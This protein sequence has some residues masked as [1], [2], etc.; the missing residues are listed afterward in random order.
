MSINLEINKEN[1]LNYLNESKINETELN[2]ESKLNENT[3]NKDIVYTNFKNEEN[4]DSNLNNNNSINDNTQNIE[5]FKIENMCFYPTKKFPHMKVLNANFNLLKE[6]LLALIEKDK[7]EKNEDKFFQP[8]IEHDLYEES[9][10]NGWDVGP[11]MIGGNYIENNCKKA[12][13][14]YN[15]V[16]EIPDIKSASFSLLKPNTHIVPHQGYDEYSEKVLRFHMGMIIPKGDLGIRVATEVRTWKEGESFIFD[17]F[18]IHEAW[19]FSNEDRYVLICDFSDINT[20]DIFEIK[21]NN[22]NK[23]VSNYLK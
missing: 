8:W 12:S 10:P 9:N 19:N 20:E 1:N 7:T 15:I 18:L 3:I 21:D 4:I 5:S 13:Y 17:D 22:F 14:L 2:K 16:K 6:E 23:S 11:I